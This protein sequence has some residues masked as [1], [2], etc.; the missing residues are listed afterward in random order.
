MP[1]EEYGKKRDFEK[2][3]EPPPEESS[4][5]GNTYAIQK[6]DASRLHYDLRLE[7]D[8]VLLSWAVPKGPSRNPADKRLAVRTED[9]PVDYADFEGAIPEDEYG[10]GAVMLWDH[11]T[12]DNA[13]DKDLSRQLEDGQLEVRIHGEKLK[14]GWA[15]IRMN[16]GD[17]ENWLLI[18]MKDEH[19]DR[20]GNITED[21][22]DS[23][24]TGRS[25]EEIAA[26][27]PEE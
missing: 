7:H 8:G 27:Q 19:A 25:L 22:P 3:S 10:G 6:H 12:Y 16:R 2:T 11:G 26:E 5:G 9:H 13:K 1:L 17:G 18:K 23:V 14:G 15:L 24:K 20:D 4:G 21:A